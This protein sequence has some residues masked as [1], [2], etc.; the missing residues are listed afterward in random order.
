MSVLLI[1]ALLGGFLALDQTSL[2]QFMLSRPLV[3][4]TLAGSILGDPASGLVVGG[5]LEVLV[6]PAF[7]IGGARFPEGGPSGVVAAVAAAGAPGVAL[8]PGVAVGV[9]MGAV[10]GLL[11]GWSVTVLRRLNER[12]VVL[13]EESSFG[14]GRIVAGHLAGLASDFLRGVIL[15]ALGMGLAL[16][17]VPAASEVWP[18]EGPGTLLLLGSVVALSA[19]GLL[20]AVDG[21]RRRRTVFLG[22]LAFGALAGWLL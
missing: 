21:W 11:G 1:L 12:F 17:V 7:P 18:L 20:A 15:T 2:G 10:W 19:G 5:F 8:G 16:W 14:A 22:G 9:A 6:L 4:A 13:P 3:S